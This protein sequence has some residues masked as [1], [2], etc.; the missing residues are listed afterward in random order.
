M[1]KVRVIQASCTTHKEEGIL[2]ENSIVIGEGDGT[3]LQYSCLLN[4]MDGGTWQVAVHGVAKSWTRLSDFTF[5]HWGRTW[6]LTP[7]F[8]PG[9][10]QGQQSL[11]GCHLW[12]HTESDTTEETQQQTVLKSDIYYLLVLDPAKSRDILPQFRDRNWETESS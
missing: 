6:Q 7:V 2:Q 12:G 5:T 8:L 4:S 11:V 10:S 1:V 3:P 9:E